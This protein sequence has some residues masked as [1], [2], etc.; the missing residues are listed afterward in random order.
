MNGIK[1][2]RDSHN[3]SAVKYDLEQIYASHVL[4]MGEADP[5]AKKINEAIQEAAT[6]SAAARDA[7]EQND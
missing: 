6:L 4:F 1:A 3:Y 7:W 5:L 2:K